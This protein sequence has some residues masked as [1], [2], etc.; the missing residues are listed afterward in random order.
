MIKLSSL[1]ENP[2]MGEP[3]DKPHYAIVLC[4]RIE[5]EDDQ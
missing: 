3:T 2:E 4:E 5:L 1:T